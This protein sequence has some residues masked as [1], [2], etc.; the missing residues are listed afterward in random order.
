MNVHPIFVH[1]PIALLTIYALM[2]IVRLP[3]FTRQPWWFYT[4]A[5]LL[6]VGVIAG[7]VAELTGNIAAE[8]YR[9]TSAQALVKMHETFAQASVF[10]FGV[11]AAA[12]LIAWGRHENI[13]A[14]L[15]AGL[16]KIWNALEAVERTIFCAPV[17]MLLALAGLMVITITGALGGALVYGP[18]VDPVVSFVYHLFF[19]Q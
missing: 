7:K 1:F 6:F 10:I 17:L 9:G 8:A 12:Y 4:K 3:I 5:V 11:L 15:P 16:Q 13:R 19:A 2:E 14:K 18:N